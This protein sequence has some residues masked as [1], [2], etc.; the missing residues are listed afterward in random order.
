[1]LSGS[2]YQFLTDEAGENILDLHVQDEWMFNQ[3]SFINQSPSKTSIRAFSN[4]EV[5]ELNLYG[6]HE[7]ISKSQSFLQLSRILDRANTRIHFFDHS[8]SPAQKYNFITESKPLLLQVFPLKMI[9]SYL[10]I[11]PETLRRVR[12]NLKI[13]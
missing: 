9:A 8:L 2:F 12:A 11:T 6:L 5:L 4:A 1:V 10:K 13:S 3:T 7:L